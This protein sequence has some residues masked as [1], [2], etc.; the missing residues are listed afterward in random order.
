MK[1]TSAG[2][3]LSYLD[4]CLPDTCRLQKMVLCNEAGTLYLA[5]CFGLAEDSWTFLGLT[6]EMSF[7][8]RVCHSLRLC[9][10]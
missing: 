1:L 6:E 5:F 3:K 8:T 10:T 9:S 2:N 7:E 4:D